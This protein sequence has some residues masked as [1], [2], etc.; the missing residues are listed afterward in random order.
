MCAGIV[1]ISV[2]YQL[3]R[4]CAKAKH[5]QGRYTTLSACALVCLA[6]RLAH[7]RPDE[8]LLIL[9]LLGNAYVKPKRGL[10]R[11]S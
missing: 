6:L 5:M 8:V 10:D 2:P 3:L 4:P 7:G 11:T 1:E 9:G